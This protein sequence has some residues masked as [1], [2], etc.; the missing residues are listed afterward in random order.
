MN[1]PPY[2]GLLIL[3]LLSCEFGGV[4]A[5]ALVGMRDLAGMVREPA[6]SREREPSQAN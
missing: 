3:G 6:I 2:R 5:L 4:L 1:A